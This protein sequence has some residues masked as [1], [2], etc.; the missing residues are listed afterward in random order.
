MTEVKGIVGYLAGPKS[1]Q[2]KSDAHLSKWAEQVH[3][4][5]TVLGKLERRP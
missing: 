2:V 3:T 4:Q 1:A 5:E